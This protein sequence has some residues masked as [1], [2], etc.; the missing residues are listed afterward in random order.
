MNSR[1]LLVTLISGSVIA[2]AGGLLVVD[3]RSRKR[4]LRIEGVL[5]SYA[6]AAKSQTLA[7]GMGSTGQSLLPSKTLQLV[8]KFLRIQPSRLD[9]YPAP[10]W[11]ILGVLSIIAP[12]VAFLATMMIGPLAWLGLPLGWI[13]LVRTVF[14]GFITRRAGVLYTQ[15]PDA[16]GMIVRSVRAGLPVPEA[17]RV[18]AEEAQPPTSG[19]FGQLYDELRLGGSLP[20]AVTKLARRNELLEYRFFAVSLSL[21]S[22]SG[23][24]LTETLEN[25]ADLIRKR[26]ALRQRAVALASEARM[27]M[28]VLALLPFVAGGGLVVA[29][30]A[31]V[32]QLVYTHAGRMILF[33]GIALLLTGLY[34][35]RVIIRKSVS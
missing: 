35:M 7:A 16:L 4:R 14:T 28:Y 13:A 31:Y 33:V 34:S 26:V 32:S 10:W 9:L 2:A 27:T 29:S 6:P 18:V 25:L 5:S 19:E 20:D 11:L 21:Q 22:Q 15:F 17:L 23:G 24:S 30:P 12:A 8:A 1:L 3:A